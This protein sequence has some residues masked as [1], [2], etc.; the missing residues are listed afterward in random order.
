MKY[1]EKYL[2]YYEN[3]FTKEKT[4]VNVT[5]RYTKWKN[6]HT[7]DEGYGLWRGNKQIIGTCDFSVAGC[8]TEKAAKAKIRN[9]M[10]DDY[11]EKFE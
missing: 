6:Y 2:T 10:K 11:W 7:D 1:G 4:P 8:K 5:Y 9:R 3:F